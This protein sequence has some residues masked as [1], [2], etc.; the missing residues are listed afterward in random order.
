MDGYQRIAST[1]PLQT[2]DRPDEPD[3]P[4]TRSPNCWSR[5]RR[6]P[7]KSRSEPPA[8]DP[9]KPYLTAR[10][11]AVRPQRTRLLEE[12]RA[13]GYTGCLNLVQRFLKT[14]KDQ[15]KAH[16]KATVRFE[17]PPGYQAQ[18]DWAH[19]GEVE[20]S[21][22]YAFVIVLCFSRMLYVTFTKSMDI[23][24]LICCQEKA[25]AYFGGVPQRILYDNM[26]QVRLPSGKLNP[27]FADFAAHYGFT[28]KTHRPYRPRTKGKVERI[29]PDLS[30]RELPQWPFL[31]RLRR[32][33]CS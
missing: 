12:I 18:A 32:S 22:I 25:F 21:K 6:S 19:V 30:P 8:L 24:T 28:V 15:H 26:A 3:I 4:G 10:W 29:G 5:R 23:P 1:R 14:L 27:Y 16:A 9:Y 7:S 2:R 11:E 33:V 20:G 31:R 17:T 13:Q